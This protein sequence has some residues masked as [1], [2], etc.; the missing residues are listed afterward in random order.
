M[1]SNRLRTFGLVSVR[2]PFTP[3]VEIATLE[4]NDMPKL[5]GG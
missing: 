5:G 3:R 4:G 2:P 1:P